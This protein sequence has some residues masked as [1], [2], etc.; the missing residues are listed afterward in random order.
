MNN[1][2]ETDIQFDDL[3]ILKTIIGKSNIKN[4]SSNN[5]CDCAGYTSTSTQDD[6]DTNQ[7]ASSV[8]QT[9]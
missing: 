3:S 4:L 8:G 6:R 1:I 2:F 9:N 7:I 5:D